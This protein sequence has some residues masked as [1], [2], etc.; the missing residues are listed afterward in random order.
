M[1]GS[2]YRG[3]EVTIVWGGAQL[4]AWVPLPL[5]GQAFELGT[6]ATRLSERA[7]AAV[8]T[9]GKRSARFG[10]L[11]TL[12]LRSEG[13][14]SSYIEGLRSPLAD[15]A[16]AEVGGALADAA[17][18]VADNLGAVVGALGSP[19]RALTE[20]DLH[21]WHRRLMESGGRLSASMVGAYRAEQSWI[22]GTSPRDA[23]YVPPPP[24]LV[25]ELMVDLV[26]FANDDALDPATHA[27]VLHAQFESIHPYGDGN[28]R[29]G[30]ILIG[31]ILCHRL[32][33]TVPPPVSVLIAR[34]PGGYLAGM[35]L[36][37]MGELDAWVEWMAA[38][39]QRSS[40]AAGELMDRSEALLAEWRMRLVHVRD[41]AAAHRVIDLLAE[42]PVQSAA[43][44]AD[45]LGV[46]ARAGQTALATLASHGIVERYRPEVK[47]SGRPAQY[48]MASELLGLVSGWPGR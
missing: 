48:W 16:A 29:I 41:D 44:I 24:E 6:R 25:G 8:V 2:I 27:A 31:W 36:F 14:A 35:T 13:V 28:G 19:R 39:L 3:H 22:G 46:S 15:A 33:L 5:A 17:S 11:A 23:A 12:L 32:D 9:A 34:D 38:A 26:A 4:R 10:P 43:T 37:R 18:Y 7:V 45:R 40:D 20:D 30:R 47:K 21:L 42:Q 1:E